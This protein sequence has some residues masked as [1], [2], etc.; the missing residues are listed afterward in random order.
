ML[1]I[2]MLLACPKIDQQ[3]LRQDDKEQAA[4]LTAANR[5]WEGVRWGEVN[6]VMEFIEDPLEKS[7]FAAGLKEIEYVEVQVLHAEL[8]PKAE[9]ENA[10]EMEIW[11][12]GTVY[13]RT[14]KIDESNVLRVIEDAQPWYRK[15]DGWYVEITKE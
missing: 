8:D 10:D 4:L 2:P 11:R 9:E 3:A 5:Y 7:R 15:A 13:V 6:R 14:E 12:T 1:L